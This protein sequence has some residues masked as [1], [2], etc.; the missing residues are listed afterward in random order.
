MTESSSSNT[1]MRI[2]ELDFDDVRY[3]LKEFLR[4]Q[5]RFKDYDFEGSGMS[6]LLDMLAYVTHYMGYYTN[7]LSNEGFIDTALI[8][9][10]V[11]SH[12][13]KLSYVPRSKA[14]ATAIVNILVTPPP[15]NVQSVLTL[16]KYT[17]VQS[18]EVDGVNYN[19][20]VMDDYVAEKNL[21]TGTFSFDTVEIKEGRS[22]VQTATYNGDENEQRR[23]VLKN[24][25][26]DVSTLVVTVT[27]SSVNNDVTIF[28]R[29]E[30]LTDLDSTTP[31]YF[32]EETVDR[33]HAVY[34]GDGVLGKGLS[35]G[36][37][38]RI[39][40]LITNGEP[41]NGANGFVITGSVGGFSNVKVFPI[42]AATGG[43]AE[44][45]IEE[46]RFN[47]PNY[48]T[49]QNRAVIAGD[50]S[51]LLKKDY[52]YV[53]QVSFWG[54]EDENPPIYGK[55][56][57][58]IK[59]KSGYT[60]TEA[61]KQR[62]INNYIRNRNVVSIIPEIVDPEY[63]YIKL[64]V[65][66]DYNPKLARTTETALRSDAYDAIMM[67]NGQRLSSFDSVFRLS[68]LQ[69]ALERVD[70]SF[71]SS[72]VRVRVE[73]RFEPILSETRNYTIDFGMPLQKGSLYNKIVSSP[74]VSVFD[75]EGISRDVYIEETP[76]SFTGI[77][78]IDI[79]NPGR[80]YSA[81]PNVSITGDGT[82]ARA[83]AKIKNRMVESIVM[84]A[85]GANYTVATVEIT[86]GGSGRAATGKAILGTS[87][88]T[89]RSYYLKTNGEKVI[90]NSNAGTIDYDEG[91]IELVDFR[92][93][94]I[95]T[96]VN[97][98]DGIVA[99][100]AEPANKNIPKRKNRIPLIDYNDPQSV[101][102]S[103]NVDGTA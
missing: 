63:L 83:V 84:T 65:R 38:V 62:I 102:I 22:F 52:P 18:E 24:P 89:L 70:K 43:S 44:E 36:N 9:N 82:G 67:Y 37:I 80:K 46:M 56:F 64:D 71:V 53:D 30:N 81:V 26:V 23:F 47:A 20:V 85:N 29:A 39:R 88:G 86:G 16:P 55:V 93:N 31:A 73:K 94:S 60:I 101:L 33:K 79:T 68:N 51:T 27:E 96:S 21:L 98:D 54:G 12:A 95:G 15:G 99:F 90:L 50:Y 59:P 77:D 13:Q 10:S 74:A 72:D 1:V 91:V 41:P 3:N 66:I 6:I 57:L 103:L 28:T 35:E 14:A 40:Y 48:Y 17:R 11:V 92:P 76:F 19:F 8:R 100:S 75:T 61:E 34:F 42:S 58:A 7:M 87:R 49:T 32:V 45:S 97:F 4:G 5:K 78:R 69:T 2:A 25:E